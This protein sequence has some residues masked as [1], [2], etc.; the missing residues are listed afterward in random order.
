MMHFIQ[1]D[2]DDVIVFKVY[3]CCVLC[4]CDSEVN[5]KKEMKGK[6]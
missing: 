3:C 4:V 6:Q 1:M 2:V 5:K